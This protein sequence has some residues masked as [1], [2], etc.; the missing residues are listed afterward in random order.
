M[1]L[2]VKIAAFPIPSEEYSDRDLKQLARKLNALIDN[3][4]NPGDLMATSLQF[5]D[6]RNN[7]LLLNPTGYGLGVGTMYYDPTTGNTKV[8]LESD[9]FAPSFRMQFKLREVT[10][11]T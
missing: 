6:E 3:V 4:F 5:Y 7:E 1:N 11:T 2:R 8:V 10:V 9:I